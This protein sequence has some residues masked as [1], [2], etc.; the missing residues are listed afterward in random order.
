MPAKLLRLNKNVRHRTVDAKIRD[1]TCVDYRGRVPVSG[2]QHLS[3][4]HQMHSRDLARA[5]SKCPE[6]G[7]PWERERNGG[8]STRCH[9]SRSAQA[10]RARWARSTTSH[11]RGA[12][13]RV[14]LHHEMQ[15]RDYPGWIA[16]SG[17]DG[18]ST[19]QHVTSQ[20][21]TFSTRDDEKAKHSSASAHA[22]NSGV[23]STH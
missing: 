19:R 8:M 6:P 2:G 15:G 23:L 21:K 10:A 11:Q 20:H 3:C 7:E 18:A 9:S 17:V 13:R 22:S 14:P 12:L 4:A 16:A 1:A 5:K